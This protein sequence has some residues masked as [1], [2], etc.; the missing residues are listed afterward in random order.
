MEYNQIGGGLTYGSLYGGHFYA[1]FSQI[2]SAGQ[3]ANSANAT[4]WAVVIRRSGHFAVMLMMFTHVHVMRRMR[5][6]SFMA[7]A[8]QHLH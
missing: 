3:M 4:G 8:L 5:Y 7:F 2:A 1:G 6:S